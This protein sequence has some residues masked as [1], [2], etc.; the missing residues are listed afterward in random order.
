MLQRWGGA[1]GFYK[2]SL[3]GLERGKFCRLRYVPK[4]LN[5][6]VDSDYDGL[7]FLLLIVRKV[8]PLFGGE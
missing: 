2:D 4:A 5:L 6:N 1:G 8:V 7:Q 3:H